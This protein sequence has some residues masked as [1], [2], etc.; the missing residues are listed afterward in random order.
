MRTPASRSGAILTIPLL[1]FF[2]I[3]CFFMVGWLAI[4]DGPATKP[5]PGDPLHKP[6]LKESDFTYLGS[7]RIPEK[8]GK[9]WST[10]FSAS[11][12]THRYVDGKLRFITASHC[13]GGGLVYE[14]DFP[15][16]SAVAPFP[17]AKVIKH[18]G[19]VYHGH[20][21]FDGN[22]TNPPVWT[23]GL[24]Y[25]T[26]RRRLYWNYGHVYNATHPYHPSLGF[27][28]L[29]DATGMA[30][31]AGPWSLAQRPE[32]YA[33][34]GTLRI[35]RWFADRFTKGRSL[36]V[37]FGGYFSIVNGASFGPALAAVNDPDVKANP[38]HSALDNVVLVGYPANA[39]DRGHRDPDYTSFYDGGF[40]PKRPG[41]WNPKKGTGYWTWSDII[42]GGATWIDMPGAHGVL[43]IGKVGQGDVWYEKSD[44]HAQRGAY[45]WFVYDPADLAAVA[46][47]RKKQWEV[48]PKHFWLDKV[49]PIDVDKNGWSG[50]GVS[51]VGGATFDARTN[52]L[53]VLVNNAWRKGLEFHPQV[54]VFQV[55]GKD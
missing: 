12:L 4:A 25:D 16:I 55:G 10:A 11:G 7:F 6:V 28:V 29:D 33:R 21:D 51:M 24:Q 9:A 15:D 36:G 38:P 39:P 50:D 31:G 53:Y 40:L 26:D 3:A 14:T 41:L 46:S 23:Y 37:G 1:P 22:S 34:G 43:F 52:R 2:G 13:Y 45:E 47:R 20:K 17:M 5:F 35:P 8:D 54:S 18:W 48:Q 19:D 30:T 32:K 44:R 49:L 42:Y 27:S